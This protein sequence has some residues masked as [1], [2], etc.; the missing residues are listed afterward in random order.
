MTG[1]TTVGAV[2]GSAGTESVTRQAEVTALAE[3]YRR[4]SESSGKDIDCWL[5]IAADEFKFGSLS[6]GAAHLAN[7]SGDGSDALRAFFE[8]IN[9]H[10]NL[11]S[12]SSDEFIACN[13]S[14][15]MR[16]KISWQNKHTG[17]VF[18]SVKMDYWH[19]RDGKAVEFFEVCDTAGIQAAASG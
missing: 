18:S 15:V 13:G 9:K 19:F 10:W 12:F 16:G 14:V 2:C 6:A 8:N 1:L 5:A 3:T 11:V 7:M 17:K 4:W